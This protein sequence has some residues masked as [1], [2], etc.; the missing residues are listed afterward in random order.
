MADLT[1]GAGPERPS[2][3][4]RRNP[5]G[6]RVLA[7]L[8]VAGAVVVLVVQNSQ[9][10]TVRFW[11]FT[12]HVRLIWVIVVCLVVAGT[13]GFLVGRRGPPPPP[14]PTRTGLSP[15]R[16]DHR[17][18][19]TTV[20]A[21]AGGDHRR[22]RAPVGTEARSGG[23][24]TPRS[25]S[26][27]GRPGS[28]PPTCCS[29]TASIRPRPGCRPTSPGSSWPGR[30]W[31][32]GPRPSRFAV[33]DRVMGVVGGG[34]QA[35]LAVIDERCALAVPDGTGVG[36]GR[37]LPRGVLHRPRRAVHAVRTGHG[38]PG[39]RDGGR[40]RGGDGRPC[41]WPPPPGPPWWRRSGRLG[42]ARRCLD[43]R[44]RRRRRPRR[45]AWR[46][47]PST[48]S[49]NWWVRRACR[50]V[51]GALAVGGRVVRDRGGAAGPRPRST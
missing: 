43:A 28:T 48:W 29:A 47:G 27:C 41:S 25:W 23:R 39:A 12:G 49:S 7:A 26:P 51:L 50:G 22:R 30:W 44:C 10:V 5:Q 11:F 3:G 2:P 15:H 38:R 18:S 9:P 4:R 17:R 16:A 19:T 8:A 34:A 46:S 24:A 6:A 20:R 45:G 40:R 42:C 36:G 21:H 35:E 33:G 1:A 31:P 14:S 13:F 32:S 37:R